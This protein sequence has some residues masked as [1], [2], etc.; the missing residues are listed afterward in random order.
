MTTGS[1]FQEA[2][3]RQ[4]ALRN[5]S[6]GSVA[7]GAHKT[8]AGRLLSPDLSRSP[9]QD[10]DHPSPRVLSD[11]QPHQNQGQGL[12]EREAIDSPSLSTG[13]SAVVQSRVGFCSAIFVNKKA[14]KGP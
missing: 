12:R 14:E 2:P 5:V 7:G 3:W 13:D 9:P 8:L 1:L 11:H 4:R 10:R 6:A